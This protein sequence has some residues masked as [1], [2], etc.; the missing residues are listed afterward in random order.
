M[1]GSSSTGKLKLNSVENTSKKMDKYIS[2][3]KV[4][5]EKRSQEVG[6]QS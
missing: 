6:K 4:L 3:D 5:T 1:W 2:N